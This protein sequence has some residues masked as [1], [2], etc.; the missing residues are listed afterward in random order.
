MLL[1]SGSDT[2]YCNIKQLNSA[3][4]AYYK[5]ITGRLKPIVDT[6]ILRGRDRI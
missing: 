2:I 3:Y 5:I 4:K 1:F 6:I